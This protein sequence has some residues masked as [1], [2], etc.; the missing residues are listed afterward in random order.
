MIHRINISGSSGFMLAIDLNAAYEMV[1]LFEREVDFTSQL[2]N[3]ATTDKENVERPDQ[4]L[5]QHS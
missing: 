4:D 3:R 1:H 5:F 2:L